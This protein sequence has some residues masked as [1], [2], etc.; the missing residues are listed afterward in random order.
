MRKNVAATIELKSLY[1]INEISGCVKL[2]LMLIA[3]LEP[4]IDV[5]RMKASINGFNI[6]LFMQSCFW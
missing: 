2:L 4:Q 3:T 6:Y 1:A 5:Q